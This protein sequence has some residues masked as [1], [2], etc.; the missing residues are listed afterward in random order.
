[1]RNPVRTRV[2]RR[3]HTN[4]LTSAIRGLVYV[5]MRKEITSVRSVSQYQKL[6]LN[7]A[8]NEEFWTKVS[9]L[10]SAAKSLDMLETIY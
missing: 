8:N 3:Y 4:D 2:R 9:T 1:M 6:L 10:I 5:Q 7:V